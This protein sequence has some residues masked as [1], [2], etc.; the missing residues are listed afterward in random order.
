MGKRTLCFL[1][2]Q[3][4]GLALIILDRIDL[5]VLTFYTL[6]KPSEDIADT[7]NEVEKPRHGRWELWSS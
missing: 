5:G 6:R 3:Q 1:P 4:A 2:G 7:D